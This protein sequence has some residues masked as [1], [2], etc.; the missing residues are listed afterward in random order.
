MVRILTFAYYFQVFDIILMKFKRSKN[1]TNYPFGKNSEEYFF[2]NIPLSQFY[3]KSITNKNEIFP[4]ILENVFWFLLMK[5]KP[6][7]FLGIGN[8][9]FPGI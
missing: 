9:K 5:K 1:Q 4:Q 8:G 2:V 6:T 3:G 7:K